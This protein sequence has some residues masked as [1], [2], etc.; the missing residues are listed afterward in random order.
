MCDAWYDLFN[1]LMVQISSWSLSAQVNN[2]QSSLYWWLYLQVLQVSLLRVAQQ[3]GDPVVV[4]HAAAAAVPPH[5]ED[6]PD[7]HHTAQC[8]VGKLQDL[9]VA[10]FLQGWEN[11]SHQSGC[12]LLDLEGE[13]GKKSFAA[14]QEISFWRSAHFMPIALFQVCLIISR[15]ITIK[16]QLSFKEPLADSQ[17]KIGITFSMKTKVELP[18]LTGTPVDWLMSAAVSN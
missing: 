18:L 15:A 17:N 9:R 3:R 10:D 2:K 16:E 7:H 12:S 13:H 1:T 11:I 6:L 5:G 8:T 14:L 4:P